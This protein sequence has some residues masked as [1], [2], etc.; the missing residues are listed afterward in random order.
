MRERWVRMRELEIQEQIIMR[1]HELLWE[2]MRELEI[3]EW[4]N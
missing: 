1:E 2:R 3:Q 4:E